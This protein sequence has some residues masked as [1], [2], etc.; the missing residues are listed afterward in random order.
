[1][2]GFKK[3][4][5]KTL[6]QHKKEYRSAQQQSAGPAAIYNDDIPMVV[7]VFIDTSPPYDPGPSCDTSSSYDSS[8]SCDSG[9]SSSCDSGSCG[10]GDGS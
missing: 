1:M 2:F 4:A 6:A 10:G 3:K 5:K 8:G 9:S 7:P